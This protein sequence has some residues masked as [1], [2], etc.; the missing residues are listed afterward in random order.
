MPFFSPHDAEHPNLVLPIARGGE[1]NVRCHDD[2]AEM[3]IPVRWFELID[4]GDYMRSENNVS[5]AKVARRW[6]DGQRRR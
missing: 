4:K 3:D 1:T 6:I 5:L 2:I